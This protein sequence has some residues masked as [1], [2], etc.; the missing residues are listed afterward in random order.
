MEPGLLFDI[1]LNSPN[2]PILGPKVYVPSSPAPILKLNNRTVIGA[3]GDP[4]KDM[5]YYQ[6]IK[7]EL[8]FWE[9]ITDAIYKLGG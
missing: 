5:Q 6:E 2:Y 9:G 7:T 1:Y 8:G 4:T 3:T